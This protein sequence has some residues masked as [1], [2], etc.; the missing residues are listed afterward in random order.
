MPKQHSLYNNPQ[1]YLCEAPA[2][3]PSVNTDTPII[4]KGKMNKF[5]SRFT[6]IQHN[7]SLL[8]E[9]ITGAKVAWV[10]DSLDHITCQGQRGSDTEKEGGKEEY[11]LRML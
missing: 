6:D 10:C 8:Y 7:G 9:T 1:I 11:Y 3:S 5:H 2:T 4:D